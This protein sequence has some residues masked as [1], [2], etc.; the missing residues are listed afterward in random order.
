ML[1]HQEI[2]KEE[3]RV[4]EYEIHRLVIAAIIVAAILVIVGTICLCKWL[5]CEPRPKL[6]RN[7]GSQTSTSNNDPTEN[8]GVGEP[9]EQVANQEPKSENHA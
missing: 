5:W 3:E 1:F 6:G 4:E 2:E 8:V 9:V 7:K